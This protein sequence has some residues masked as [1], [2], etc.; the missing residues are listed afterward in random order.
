MY[1]FPPGDEV[2]QTH[3]RVNIYKTKKKKK[4]KKCFKNIIKVKE[5]NK[6][7]HIVKNEYAYMCSGQILSVVKYT[8]FGNIRL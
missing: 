8:K 5:L 4:K 3:S 7:K 1:L 2:D 6:L